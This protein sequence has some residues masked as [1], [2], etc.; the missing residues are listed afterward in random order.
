MDILSV[1]KDVCNLKQLT[2]QSGG[3]R[4]FGVSLLIAGE[5]E[6]G[7]KLFET[8]PTG[9]FNQYKATVIGEGE[10]EA[11]EEIHKGY[12]ESLSIEDGLKLAVKAM[13]KVLKDDLNAE[14]ID[15]AYIK[16]GSKGM[17]KFSKDKIAEFIK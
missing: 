1:V 3:L 2:T 12:K 14:R 13:K 6:D 15:A 10:T 5:D 16:K 4:P 11:E 9:I 8:D 7:L 17:E